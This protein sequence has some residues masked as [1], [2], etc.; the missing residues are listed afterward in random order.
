MYAGVRMLVYVHIVHACVWVWGG[1][2][3][4]GMILFSKCMLIR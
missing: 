4:V 2:G 3:A 1:G